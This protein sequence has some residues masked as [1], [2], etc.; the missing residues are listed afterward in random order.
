ME[1]LMAK[2]QAKVW[3]FGSSSSS[4]TYQTIQYTDGYVS[5]NCPGWTRRAVRECK[6]T[7]MVHM[8]SADQHCTMCKDLLQAKA[9]IQSGQVKTQTA[10]PKKV[11]PKKKKTPIK[12]T[13]EDA[14]AIVRKI[15]W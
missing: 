6:H 10:A 13:S 5:C 14:P 7:N 3:E 4:K 9:A 15:H 1:N 11:A 2:E 12:K 8:G